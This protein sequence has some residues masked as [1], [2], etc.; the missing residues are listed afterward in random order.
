MKLKRE[1]YRLEENGVQKL[2]KERIKIAS[3]P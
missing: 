3:C 1:C 2:K